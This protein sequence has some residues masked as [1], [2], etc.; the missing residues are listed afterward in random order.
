MADLEDNPPSS[1][2]NSSSEPP[3][4]AYQVFHPTPA[5]AASLARAH[6]RGAA[7]AQEVEGLRAA[8]RAQE[9][10]IRQAM[11][12]PAQALGGG[13]P[14]ASRE[15]MTA[16]RTRTLSFARTDPRIRRHL[17]SEQRRAEAAELERLE[18]DRMRARAR[19][20]AERLAAR[21]AVVGL[22]IA[23]VPAEA[24]ALLL[25]LVCNILE[26]PQDARKRKIRL[27]NRVLRPIAA[28]NEAQALLFHVGFVEVI[29]CDDEGA[30]EPYLVLQ[31]AEWVGGHDGLLGSP[32]VR[33]KL[34]HARSALQGDAPSRPVHATHAAT[35]ASSSTD[36]VGAT[37]PTARPDARSADVPGQPPPI[38][39]CPLSMEVM[40][41]PVITCL[42]NT[43]SRD[44]IEGWFAQCA[45]DGRT[46]TDPL[47]GQELPSVQLIENVA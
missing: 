40:D 43:Y 33:R 1:D 42:G 20:Q 16:Q 44:A 8:R 37:Q 34:E 22:D 5:R 31:C 46:P 47:C 28:S 6:E 15:A 26:A 24:R 4:P 17:E 21:Q 41:D 45:A 38:I 7:A 19:E 27:S 3:H 10:E 29:E 18:A 35:T 13:R 39:V 36:N 30:E 2:A 12:S 11:V 32:N 23:A 9:A 25:R 14:A